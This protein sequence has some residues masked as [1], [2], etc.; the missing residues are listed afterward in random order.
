MLCCHILSI[1]FILHLLSASR[2]PYLFPPI[3]IVGDITP[4]DGIS[5][6]EKSQRE[7]EAL[8]HMCKLLGGGPQGILF[9]LARLPFLFAVYLR[10]KTQKHVKLI[11]CF[12][13]LLIAAKE[14][15]D[16]WTEYEE[17]TSLEAK[18]VKD[19]DKV[20]QDFIESRK[21]LGSSMILII[22][23]WI[24]PHFAFTRDFLHPHYLLSV[25][26]SPP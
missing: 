12:M 21:N 5:K 8:E 17:N 26:P 16:L 15:A 25:S 19:L 14:I 13:I 6:L 10:V 20:R 23:K 24:L 7:Q 4:S 1:F 3:A 11:S 2:G 18:V 22:V 9:C